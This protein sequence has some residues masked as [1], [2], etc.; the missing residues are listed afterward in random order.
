MDKKKKNHYFKLNPPQQNFTN[1]CQDC[2]KYTKLF[3]KLKE[4]EDQCHQLKNQINFLSQKFNEN[5][6]SESQLKTG[7]AENLCEPLI[8]IAHKLSI[9]DNS[10]FEQLT[11]SELEL[12]QDSLHLQI[13]NSRT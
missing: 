11:P 5:I 13:S 3:L 7:I 1:K 9:R 12:L 6:S 8:K 2:D 10:N 4:R